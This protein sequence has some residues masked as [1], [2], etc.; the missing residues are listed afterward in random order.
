MASGNTEG[1]K[2]LQD[3]LDSVPN[4]VEMFFNDTISPHN[5]DQP[6]VSPV[7]AEFSN[8]IDEQRAW[9]ET[10]VIFD[11][12]HH[13][14]ELFLKGPDALRLLARIGINS[15]SNFVP[16]KAKQ[17][18]ACSPSGFLIGD[19]ILYYLD[20]QSFELVSG[21]AVLD[22]IH[23]QAEV[24]GYKVE[25]KR[26]NATSLQH[27]ERIRFR[28]QLDGPNAEKIFSDVVEGGAP[29][30][31][32]FG[33]ARVRIAG[34]DVLALRHGM[35]GHKG[36][37][38]SGDFPQRDAVIAQIIK[39]GSKHG[40]RRGGTK[41]YY[42]TSGESG[43]LPT[44]LPAIYTDD[45]L[46]EFRQ[47]LPANSWAANWNLAGSFYSKNIEDYYRTIWEM[48]YGK[49]IKFDHDFIGRPALERMVKEEQRVRVTL[50][51]HEEEVSRLIDSH[52]RPGT[53]YKFPQLPVAYFGFRQYDEVR[54]ADGKLI[55]LANL[56]SYSANERKML[57]LATLDTAH[58]IPGT[59][60]EIVWGEPNGGTRKPH[61][62]RH[63]Q[64]NVRATVAPAPYV[65][66]VRQAKRREVEERISV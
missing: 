8:W 35:A 27:R 56:H 45:E 16:G 63:V 33:T 22:W 59:E 52:F 29:D 48:G 46:R 60:V 25:V 47:W 18:V 23:F 66:F 51:W 7:P 21:G 50:A 11:Q 43:W 39:A 36:Y 1:R 26:D 28:Y 13:M 58:A 10:A 15:F 42:S 6:G 62:E 12:S 9:R 3:V 49:I 19:C 34:R 61:V 40:L 64:T 24:G 2:S 5:R 37:E 44:T 41:A 31:P 65:E 53:P 17:F 14:P 32:F 57:S 54:S 30:I 4:L 55:G 20:D 38:L